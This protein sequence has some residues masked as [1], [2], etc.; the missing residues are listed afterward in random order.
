MA[1]S[2]FLIWGFVVRVWLRWFCLAVRFSGVG[3]VSEGDV[4]VV[5]VV[6]LT[7]QFSGEVDS[8]G[9]QLGLLVGVADWVFGFCD[10]DC[11][12]AS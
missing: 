12:E 1:V 4:A 6:S 3:R 10:C 2:F 7:V 8:R 11:L 9:T 5:C